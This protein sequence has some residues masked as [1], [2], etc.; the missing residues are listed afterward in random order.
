MNLE[1]KTPNKIE[2]EQIRNYIREFELDNRELKQD[3]FVAAYRNNELV[4]FGRLRERGDCTELCSLGVI[5]TERRKG[6]GKAIVKELLKR[7]KE[8]LYLVCII[9]DF[10]APFKFQETLYYPKSIQEKIDYCT[11]ELIVPEKYVAM[12]Y[13]K[14]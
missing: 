13:M 3:Q 8:E 2:F 14:N 5:T 10:F 9:P 11:A 1:L 7:S 12:K 4:G 6:I